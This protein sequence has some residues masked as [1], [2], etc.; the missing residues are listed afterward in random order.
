VATPIY[1][2][3]PLD[4]LRW[5]EFLERHNNATLFHSPEWLEALRRTYGY[6]AGAFTTSGPGERLTNGLAFCRVRSW[7]TGRRLISIPFSDHGS[8]LTDTGEEFGSLLSRLQQEADRDKES[9]FELRLIDGTTGVPAGLTASTRFCL[10]RLDLRPGL[11]QLFRALH[12][13][14]IRR[15]IARAQRESVDYAEG[16]SDELLRKYYHL[17]VLTRRRQQIPPQPL[18]WFQNLIACFGKRVKIR[19]GLHQGQPVAGIFTIRYKRTLTY[20]YGCSDVLFHRLGSMQMLMWKA[21]QEAKADGLLTFDMGRTDW[22][23]EGLITYKDRWGAARSTLLY[24]R[25][26]EPQRTGDFLSRIAGRIASWAPDRALT[27]AGNVLYR[28]IA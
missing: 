2:I 9:Y 22:S 4:D 3:D 26:P 19:L 15:K 24:V 1:E 12:G 13:D 7:L 16:T 27:M 28:H 8:P 17:A 5:P 20:K 11:N 23:N 14:C 10:H 18:S 25:H 6:S 21:I